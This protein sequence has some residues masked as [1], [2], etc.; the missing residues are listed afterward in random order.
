MSEYQSVVRSVPGS[1]R[2][3]RVGEGVLAFADFPAA[4]RKKKFVV[5]RRD[6]QR[7]RRARY[8]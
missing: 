5:A 4:Y 1:A 3:S 6:D 8:P 2:V 7:A